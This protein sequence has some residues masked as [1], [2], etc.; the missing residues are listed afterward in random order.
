MCILWAFSLFHHLSLASSILLGLRHPVVLLFNPLAAFCW[1]IMHKSHNYSS[2][3]VRLCECVCVC[4][5]SADLKRKH[6]DR[7]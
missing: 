5:R 3:R 4:V 1:D 6:T 7:K 2:K